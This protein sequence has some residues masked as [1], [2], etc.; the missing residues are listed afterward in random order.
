MIPVSSSVQ[1]KERTSARIDSE[2]LNK[3]VSLP[4][5][6]IAFN[7]IIKKDKIELEDGLTAKEYKK[8]YP[9]TS[10]NKTVQSNSS[11]KQE[12]SPDEIAGLNLDLDLELDVDFD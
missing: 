6:T 1:H 8:L 7:S 3:I 10:N 2:I 11:I 4:I 12:L 9:T 5:D